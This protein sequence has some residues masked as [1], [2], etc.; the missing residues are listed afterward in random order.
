MKKKLNPDDI[1]MIIADWEDGEL[2][3]CEGIECDNCPLDKQVPLPLR[4]RKSV[5]M[6]NL[7]MEMSLI[8]SEVEH[9]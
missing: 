3:T 8:M 6:C 7:I 4:T 2:T 1:A 9:D 5:S